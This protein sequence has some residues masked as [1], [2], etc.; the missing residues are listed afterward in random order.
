M[1]LHRIFGFGILALFLWKGR[2]II[3]SLQPGTTGVL[4]GAVCYN[5]AIYQTC[6]H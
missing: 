5:S 6:N 1:H 4:S 2:N 3:G